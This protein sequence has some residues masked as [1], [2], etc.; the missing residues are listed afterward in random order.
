MAFLNARR[1]QLAALS[2]DGYANL[3]RQQAEECRKQSESAEDPSSRSIFLRLAAM[4]HDMA[5]QFAT[6]ADAHKGNK[7]PNPTA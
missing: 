3:Y 4:Y 6:R 5:N 7:L 2:G 1:A